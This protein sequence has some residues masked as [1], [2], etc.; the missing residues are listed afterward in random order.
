MT[1]LELEM[2]WKRDVVPSYIMPFRYLIEK[3]ENI[4]RYFR[5]YLKRGPG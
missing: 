4:M 1:A 3:K 2:M 5:Q